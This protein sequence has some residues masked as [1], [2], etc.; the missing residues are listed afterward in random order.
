MLEVNKIYNGDCLGLLKKLDDNSINM[1]ITSPPYYSMR[2]Y[3]IEND[4]DIQI[5]QEPKYQDYINNLKEIFIECNRVLTKDGSIYVNISDTYASKGGASRHFGYT[6]PKFLK[7]RRGDFAEPSSYKQDNLKPTSMMLIPERFAIMM[8]DIGFILRNKII[9]EKLNQMPCS[10]KTRFT[11]SFEFLYFFTKNEK[12]KFYTQLED[13]ITKYENDK[14]CGGFTR[15]RNLNYNTKYENLKHNNGNQIDDQN[16]LEKE[17]IKERKRIMRTV[18]KINTE[19]LK[20]EH[21]APFP[22]KLIETPILASTD[23]NDIVL[24]IFMGSGT[25]ALK[26]IELKRN[27][28][29]FEASQKYCKIAEN[30]IDNF[31]KELNNSL[32]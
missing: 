29:G 24:D 6:D 2:N 11:N 13:C 10:V 17:N 7:S 3:E 32:F 15:T 8:T 5:G 30:R 18:W 20:D 28:I 16:L 21:I 26:C 19:P 12:Y 31:K 22:K 27:Y 25:T 1:V 9:W 4:R 14:R 23:E